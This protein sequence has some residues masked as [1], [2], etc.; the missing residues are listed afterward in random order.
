[1]I[2]SSVSEAADSSRT[3]GELGVQRLFQVCRALGLHTDEQR[4]VDTFQRMSRSWASEPCNAPPIWPSEVGDDHTPFELSVAFRRGYAPELRFMVEPLGFPASLASNR[5]A[6]LE[7]MGSLPGL[8]VDLRRVA[9]VQDLLL[10]DDHRGRFAVWLAASFRQDARPELKAYF[11]PT[12]HGRSAAPAVV[13]ETLG[14]LGFGGAWPALSRYLLARG[15]MQDELTYVS[16]DLS[17]SEGARLK[18]YV[19]HHHAR[20]S[21]LE[22]AAHAC[23]TYVAGDVTRFLETLA[24]RGD[25]TFE[26]RGLFTCLSFVRERGQRAS[27]VTFHFP[28]NGYAAD[29]A[30]IGAR[31]VALLGELGIDPGPYRA[32]IDAVASRPLAGGVGVHSYVSFRRDGRDPRITVYLPA[33]A[34]APGMV[35][36]PNGPTPPASVRAVVAWYEDQEPITGHPFVRRLRRESPSLGR[37]YALLANFQAAISKKFAGHLARVTARVPDE[38]MRCLLSRQLADELGGGVWERAHVNLFSAMMER[39]A[40][41]RPLWFDDQALGPG[42]EFDRRLTKVIDLFIGEEVRRDGS[43]DAASLEWLT[44]HE[45]LEVLHA[46]DSFVLADLVPRT[47]LAAARRGA[48]EAAL[49]GW[50]FLDDLYELCFTSIP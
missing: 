41:H 31:V 38:R 40:E 23:P 39:L 7:L 16:L 17:P 26:G 46:E 4:V 3:L 12:A 2:W 35:A 15:S 24:S 18:I 44:L 48:N 5:V 27:G 1:M 29:D 37:Q 30:V 11:D 43:V 19:R 9:E 45:Q 25:E 28:I 34:Y 47:D 49:A 10:P 13:E 32:T 42:L 22:R 36:A 14:R 8:D 6:S 50:K 21:D 33:E 20:A